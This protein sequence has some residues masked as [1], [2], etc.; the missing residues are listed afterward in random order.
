[1][2]ENPRV[3]TA[4]GNA[5]PGGRISSLGAV[6]SGPMPHARADVVKSDG[7]PSWV[8]RNRYAR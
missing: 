7:R 5:V 4:R 3:K 1:M 2:A 6:G 8:G